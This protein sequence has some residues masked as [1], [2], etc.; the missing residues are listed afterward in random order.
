MSVLAKEQHIGETHK[1]LNGQMMTI[2]DWKGFS[3]IGVRFEDGTEV[4]GKRYDHFE[5]GYINNPNCPT[6]KRSSKDRVG[7]TNKAS[8]GLMMTIEV[9][10]SATDLDVRFE[11]G[12]LVQH[13]AYK[14]F[15]AGTIGCPGY[16]RF[17][18]ILDRYSG[19]RIKANNGQMMEVVGGTA[20]D[21]LTIR[22][23]DGTEVPHVRS[24][25][26][27]S[28]S[29]V[30][31]NY[32]CAD[33]ERESFI[34]LT[35]TAKNGLKMTVVDFRGYDDIDVLFE[36]G[37]KVYH[38]NIQHFRSGDIKHPNINIRIKTNRI[39]DTNLAVCGLNMEILEYSKV[40]DIKI[41]FETGYEAD[42]KFYRNFLTGK[43][44]HPFPYNVGNVTMKKL[45]YIYQN[46]GNFYCT[47]PKCG[48]EDIMTLQEVRD[49]V[50]QNI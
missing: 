21:D 30:N 16:G 18:D 29:V 5:K 45:A 1:A 48:M 25:S 14:E 3:N 20:Y 13:K 7:Q 43:I 46:I 50:C 4:S 24:S 44:G 15:L 10:R 37:V 6:K 39:G 49:H 9:Y 40:D 41:R 23:E 26:F 38:K 36:D 34:G 2:I 47:C 28:G 31:P 32:T 17:T 27:Y 42:H 8:N 33:K 19:K 12:T 11:N 35:N 22:F